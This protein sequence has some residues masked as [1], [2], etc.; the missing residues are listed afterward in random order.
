M[1]EEEEGQRRTR[2]ACVGEVRLSVDQWGRTMD[3][4]PDQRVTPNRQE[5]V[6]YLDEGPFRRRH[7]TSQ[8]G[9]SVSTSAGCTDFGPNLSSWRP[10]L[11]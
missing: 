10:I 8:A 6:S 4:M 1:N 2:G 7:L 9:F 11:A 5:Q 3:P